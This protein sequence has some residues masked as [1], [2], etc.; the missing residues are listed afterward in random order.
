ML[1]YELVSPKLII[2]PTAYRVYRVSAWLSIL[3]FV[4]VC[5]TLSEGNVPQ[6]IAPFEQVLLFIFAL[7]AACTLAGMEVFLFRFDKS[8][9]LKQVCWFCAMLL[10]PLGAAAYCFFVYSRSDLF[11]ARAE[12]A[13]SVSA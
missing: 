3:L 2:S 7:A 5:V 1:K 8:H 10:P 11:K 13:R 9:A 6:L 4:G 12:Q